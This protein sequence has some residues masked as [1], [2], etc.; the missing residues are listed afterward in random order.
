MENRNKTYVDDIERGIYDVKNED[1]FEFKAD[2]GLTREIVETISKEKNEPEWMLD[3]RLKAYHE[4]EKKKW[5]TFGPDLSSINFDEYIY[6]IKSSEKT[7]SSW[8]QVPE[9]EKCGHKRHP[10]PHCRR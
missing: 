9:N 5:P 3:I 2:K 7:E 4:F 1:K 8:D 6:Y 10:D